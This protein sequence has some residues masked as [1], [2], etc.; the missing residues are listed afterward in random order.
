MV[1]TVKARSIPLVARA[2]AMALA[3]AAAAHAQS[4]TSA[5]AQNASKEPVLDEIVVTADRKGSYSAE[6][7]FS[8]STRSLSS[9]GRS[10]RFTIGSVPF[11]R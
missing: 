4:Q 7:P 6:A 11:R 3:M 10:M 2:V 9:S 5:D 8:A 1:T